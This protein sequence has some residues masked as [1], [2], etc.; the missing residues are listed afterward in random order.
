MMRTRASSTARAV[1]S[2]G[3]STSALSPYLISILVNTTNEAF[4]NM[5]KSMFSRPIGKGLLFK[6]R[7]YLVNLSIIVFLN[8]IAQPEL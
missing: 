8:A 7:C 6:H 1:A 5:T 2:A 4:C 3:L